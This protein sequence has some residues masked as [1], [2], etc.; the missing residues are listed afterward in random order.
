MLGIMGI[1][2]YITLTLKQR[3]LYVFITVYIHL[4]TTN[5]GY[6]IG[7]MEIM[8]RAFEMVMDR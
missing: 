6:I 1:R 4:G 7:K 8:G 2:S 3:L 5:I